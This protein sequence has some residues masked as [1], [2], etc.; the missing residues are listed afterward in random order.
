MSTDELITALREQAGVLAP[1]YEARLLHEAADTIEAQAER[2][3]IMEEG[4]R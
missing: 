3:A 1:G 2:I 4:C